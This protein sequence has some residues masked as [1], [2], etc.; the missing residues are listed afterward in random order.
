MPL[1]AATLR[2]AYE[3]LPQFPE[4]RVGIISERSV[5][6]APDLI[7]EVVHEVAEGCGSPD[8]ADGGNVRVAAGAGRSDTY[9]RYNSVIR[10]SRLIRAWRVAGAPRVDGDG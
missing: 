4:E 10:G 6:G 2:W 7:T 9:D 1:D 3:E 5:E 8:D